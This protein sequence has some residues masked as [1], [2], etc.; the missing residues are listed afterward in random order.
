MADLL[1]NLSKKYRIYLITQVPSE[2]SPQ[3]SNAKRQISELVDKK[4]V[5]EH[6]VMFCQTEKGKE[7]LIR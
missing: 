1:P 2:D 3:Y 4:A 6:R 7:S 5:Q